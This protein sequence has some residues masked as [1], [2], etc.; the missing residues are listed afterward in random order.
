MTDDERKTLGGFWFGD[1]VRAS[2]VLRRHNC[3]YSPRPREIEGVYIGW[4]TV[5]DGT[6]PGWDRE[7]DFDGYK[8]TRFYTVAVVVPGPRR[9]PVYVLP[10]HLALEARGAL[11]RLTHHGARRVKQ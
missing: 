8:P 9:N 5:S 6:P 1:L 4:R 3:R 2:A 11:H 10:K 7:G